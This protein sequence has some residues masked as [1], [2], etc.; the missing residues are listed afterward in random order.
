MKPRIAY[1]ASPLGILR[2]QCEGAALKSVLFTELEEPPPSDPDPLLEQ[3]A[4]QLQEYFSGERRTFQ[5]PLVPEGTEFQKKVWELLGRIPFGKTLS[6]QALSLQYGDPK[7][8]RAV[9]SANGKNPFAVIVPC[10]RV[11]GSNQSLTGYAGGLWRKRWL[12][13]HEARWHHGVQAL[14]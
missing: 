10:H 6:Y 5:L 11:V 3:C 4:I 7:A 13:E 1:M 9:A 2:L 12:L 8:I 14:F